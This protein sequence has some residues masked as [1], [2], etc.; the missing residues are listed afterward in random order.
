MPRKKITLFGKTYK[1][2]KDFE[3]YV[4]KIIYDVV[5]CCK[6]IRVAHPLQYNILLKILERHPE[7]DDKTKNIYTLQ[8]RKNLLNRKALAI[9]IINKDGQEIDISW[10]CAIT[11]NH[12]SA[13]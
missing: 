8:I 6:D 3:K 11:G 5:G 1:T 10:R 2:Q 13:R 12:K 7:Y 4:K 9:F